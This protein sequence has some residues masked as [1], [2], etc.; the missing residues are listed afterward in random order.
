[1]TNCKICGMPWCE[2]KGDEVRGADKCIAVR[3][4]ERLRFGTV[5]HH[6]LTRNYQ[7]ENWDGT[8]DW[9]RLMLPHQDG[10]L[11][12]NI[13]RVQFDDKQIQSMDLRHFVDSIVS[14]C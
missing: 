8:K 7:M 13:V 4:V 12:K 10:E 3:T 11:Q 1:M 5:T 6:D 14:I 9:C 2:D